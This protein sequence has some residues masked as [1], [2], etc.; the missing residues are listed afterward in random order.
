VNKEEK[1]ITKTAKERVIYLPKKKKTLKAQQQM[2]SMCTENSN[3]TELFN[4]ETVPA[5]DTYEEKKKMSSTTCVFC[6][7]SFFPQ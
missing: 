4:H 5:A 1:E 6:L 7:S 3:A 2:C